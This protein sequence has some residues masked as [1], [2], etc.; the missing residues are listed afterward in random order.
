MS[1]TDDLADLAAQT[2]SMIPEDIKAVME[3][4]GVDLLNSGIVDRSLQ[5]GDTI[6][7]F[8][9]PN[10]IGKPIAIQDLLKLGSVVISFYRGDWCP[11][12]NL[13][14]RALQQA[15]PQFQTY[16]A[17][18]VAISPQTPDNSLS[19]VEK[20]ELSFEVLS[21]V[22]NQVAHKFGLVY[23]VP[24]ALRP[25][26]QQFGIDLPRANGD[27][28]FALPIPATYVVRPDGTI[29]DAFVNSDYTQRQDPEKII[30]ILSN[31]ENL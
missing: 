24:E 22:G 26:Y 2:H 25:I 23:T 16:G 9:L 7:A 14:L 8:V 6:P 12:C 3:Q 21:D 13:E 11:Y 28:T 20:D 27:E 29:A 17:T 1:L 19:T 4:A 18:L 30:S 5:T 15:L 31:L 10:A